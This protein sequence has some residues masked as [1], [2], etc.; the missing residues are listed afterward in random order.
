MGNR[1]GGGDA[2]RL[3]F[4]ETDW[5]SEIED[6]F[7]FKD[8]AK[9]KK[10]QEKM[11]VD[12]AKVHEFLRLRIDRPASKK[13]IREEFKFNNETT[14]QLLKHL[15]DR[16]EAIAPYFNDADQLSQLPGFVIAENAEL[17]KAKVQSKLEMRQKEMANL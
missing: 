6:F 14:T 8:T 5:T 1:E 3:V 4:D 9:E 11:D 12:A 7:E 17:A 2:I 13:A 16:V 10:R 15:G